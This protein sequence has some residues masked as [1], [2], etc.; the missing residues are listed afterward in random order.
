MSD[1]RFRRRTRRR[2]AR[3]LSARAARLQAQDQ[4]DTRVEPSTTVG[5]DDS[6][7]FEL[8]EGSALDKT[9]QGKRARVETR[10]RRAD[11]PGLG[12]SAP[13]AVASE[14]DVGPP[15]EELLFRAARQ[16]NAQGELGRAAGIYRELLEI[17]PA[18][19]RARTNLALLLDQPGDHEAA[20]AELDRCLEFAPDNA[21]VLVNRG[22]VL[23]ALS[24]FGDAE[25]DLLRAL[26]LDSSNA[27]AHFNLGLVISRRGLWG[28]AVPYL[29]RSIELDSSRAGA[30]LHLGDALNHV[31]D[32]EGALHA[33]QRA[34]ELR[35]NNPRA[36]Y[37]LGIVL[38][39]L[40]RPDEAAQMYRRSRELD[41]P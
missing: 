4:P 13:R 28:D 6:L 18:D 23:S 19:V 26:R 27:E 2:S 33:Y 29:R 30:Y 7:P 8:A 41:G 40:N 39:R 5:I 3:E 38:D 9:D 21:Q 24:R 15:P 10:G 25:R 22:A 37:G 35:P 12:G 36:L 20:L 31:D 17:N 11:E 32:L 1:L 14:A 16:A 34:V